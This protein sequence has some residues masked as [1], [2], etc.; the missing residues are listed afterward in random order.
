M[1]SSSAFGLTTNVASFSRDMVVG[2]GLLSTGPRRAAA[3]ALIFGTKPE[4]GAA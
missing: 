1:W 4:E 2:G 3:E